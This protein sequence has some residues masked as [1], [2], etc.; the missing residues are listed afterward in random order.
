MDKYGAAGFN[1]SKEGLN[2]CHD[3]WQLAKEGDW[4]TKNKD[5]KIVVVKKSQY[6]HD[7]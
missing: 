7:K 6:I 5:G 1:N 2:L 4:I 3:G